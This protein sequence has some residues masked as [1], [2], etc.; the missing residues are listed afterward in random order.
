MNEIKLG[1]N[2]MIIKV[3]SYMKRKE[4][5]SKFKDNDLDILK[6]I[7][8]ISKDETEHI[9]KNTKRKKNYIIHSK[10]KLS[11]K[12]DLSENKYFLL[13]NYIYIQKNKKIS[14]FIYKLYTDDLISFHTIFLFIDFFLDINDDNKNNIDLYLSNII[15]IISTIKK[16]IKI[17]KVDIN[18]N[19]EL[20]NNDIYN[21][22]QKIFSFNNME[23][24]F[25][26]I[27]SKNLSEFPKI[28]SLLK[29]CCDYYNNDILNDENKKYI[30]NNLRNLYARNLSN[31]HLN[32]LYSV[33]RKYLKSNFNNKLKNYY[34]FFHE[35]IEFFDKI[36]TNNENINFLG[37]YFIFDSSKEKKGILET[38]PIR[39]SD[40][41]IIKELNLSFLFSFRLIKNNN[42]NNKNVILSVNDYN[43][44][45][46]IFRFIIKNND[47]C[48]NS[49][50]A[51]NKSKE[52]LKNIE[53]NKEYLCF[54][55]LDENYLYFH[56]S[57]GGIIRIN[58]I[59][60][61]NINQIYF[62]LGNINNNEEKDIKKFNGL[63]GPVLIFNS[64]IFNPLDIYQKINDVFGNKYYLLGDIINNDTIYKTNENIF[65]DYNSYYGI[66]NY[67]IKSL[68][69]VTELKEILNNLVFYINPEVVLNNLNFY[70][71]EKFRDYQI[72][73]NLF[74]LN[75]NENLNRYYEFHNEKNIDDLVFIQNSFIEFF[76]NNQML[77]FLLLNIELIYNELLICDY[78]NISEETYILL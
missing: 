27:L 63:I 62:E 77:D 3:N 68:N 58:K 57:K 15:S 59:K 25:D 53:Y 52:L 36:M 38:S 37:R 34:S 69:V 51:Y 47:L 28:L 70:Y 41:T 73:N 5:K 39:I 65:F 2:D 78:N 49:S 71:G 44:K 12:Y 20:I 23:S 17:T 72:Y 43:T 40:D 19:K 24:I 54:I 14:P 48:F 29:L 31:E 21:L 55:Y 6:K 1:E 64:K 13:H 18:N 10:N 56:P 42:K 76:N 16:I 74:N 32:Y 35:I 66:N 7:L 33:S 46:F 50:S 26:I 11:L 45:K 75:N 8:S 60:L 22:F 30:R 9:D 67:N 61:N 4:I